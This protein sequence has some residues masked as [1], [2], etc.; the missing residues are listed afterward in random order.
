VTRLIF[1]PIEQWDDPVTEWRR[2]SPFTAGWPD[3]A[4]LLR[5]EVKMLEGP[6]VDSL[7]VVQLDVPASAIRQDDGL[8][9]RAAVESPRCVVSFDSRYGPLR[10]ACDTYV[11]RSN[12]RS[13]WQSNARAIA[14]GLE[15]LRAVARWGIAGRGEQYTGFAQLGSGIPM[16]GP[17]TVD[18]AA[19]LLEAEANLQPGT[20]GGYV[21]RDTGEVCA[22]A[23]I[24]YRRAAKRHHPDAG[25]DPAMFRRLT[26]ARDLLIGATTRG[27]GFTR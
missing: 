1:R 25:G 21:G 2:E 24:A 19:R 13:S 27:T 4:S 14:K 22:R 23:A 15:A 6:G 20:V 5:R 3:T 18:E 17:M 7:I 12:S 26:E 10:Y 16:P 11:L 9:S 8:A